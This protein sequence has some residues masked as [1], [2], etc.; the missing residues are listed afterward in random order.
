MSICH[1]DSVRFK[2]AAMSWGCEHEKSAIA[3]N[4]SSHQQ[5]SVSPAGLFISVKHQYYVGASHQMLLFP[6][7]VVDQE[8]AKS[9]L[10][11]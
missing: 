2:T 11:K 5:L 9:R 3:K 6:A 10:A 4:A 8:Y 7:A 1:L